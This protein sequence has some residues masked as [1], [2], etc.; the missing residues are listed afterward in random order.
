MSTSARLVD[1]NFVNATHRDAASV[2]RAE[3]AEVDIPGEGMVNGARLAPYRT[4][5]IYLYTRENDT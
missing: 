3:S 2:L 4:A 1:L 5:H